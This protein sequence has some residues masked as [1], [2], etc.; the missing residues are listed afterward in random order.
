[1][2]K[3]PG[4]PKKKAGDVKSVDLRIP[5]TPQQKQKIYAA[6]G[7]DFASWARGILLA[8]AGQHGDGER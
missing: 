2:K 7:G 4:R 6:A 1:M 8:A 3:R 5:V